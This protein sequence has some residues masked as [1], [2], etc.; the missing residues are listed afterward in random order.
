MLGKIESGAITT[1]YSPDSEAQDRG[2]PAG[3]VVIAYGLPDQPLVMIT[4][5]PPD[6]PGAPV[7]IA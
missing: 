5:A 4:F 2:H 1:R 6:Q 3:H 7:V